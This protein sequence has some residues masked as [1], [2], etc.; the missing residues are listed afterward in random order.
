[1]NLLTSLLLKRASGLRMR[2]LAVNFL[3]AIA[4]KPFYSVKGEI[5]LVSSRPNR[6]TDTP[7]DSVELLA[8]LG[9]VLRSPALAPFDA[10]RIERA[11]DDVVAHARQVAHAA[12]P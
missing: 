9:P 3:N 10:Q 2:S 12:A 1:M 6:S 11:A 7:T 5:S 4:R 8:A